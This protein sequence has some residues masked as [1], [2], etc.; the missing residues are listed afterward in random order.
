MENGIDRTGEGWDVRSMRG[1]GIGELTVG[2]VLRL[3]VGSSRIEVG[4]PAELTTDHGAVPVHA[5][6]RTNL[7]RLPQ[8]LDQVVSEVRAADSGSLRVRFA[9]GWRLD[10]PVSSA[11]PGWVI[12][13]RNGCFISALPGGG[14][15]TSDRLR[16]RE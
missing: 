5:S 6:T 12:G 1:V 3:H 13:L 4:G 10:V 15:R 7:D 2:N 11:A 9:N 16:A 8:L 14:V